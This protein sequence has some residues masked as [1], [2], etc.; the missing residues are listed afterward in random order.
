ML[1]KRLWGL[2]KQKNKLSSELAKPVCGVCIYIRIEQLQI[3]HK[4]RLA[5]MSQCEFHG[6][7]SVAGS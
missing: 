6:Q 4:K 1:R 3:A 2:Q 7:T 5:C